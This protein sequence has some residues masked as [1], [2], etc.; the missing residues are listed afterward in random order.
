M[1]DFSL[2]VSQFSSLPVARIYFLDRDFLRA[3]L[4]FW[5]LT[6]SSENIVPRHWGA[7][8]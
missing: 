7:P 3:V 5:R 6:S 4:R 2:T 8:Q 1:P